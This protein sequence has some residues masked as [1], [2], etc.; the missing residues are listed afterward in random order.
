M[1]ALLGRSIFATNIIEQ[2]NT[3]KKGS[4]GLASGFQHKIKGNIKK[5]CLLFFVLLQY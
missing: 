4:R 2:E 5:Y 1:D 3:N